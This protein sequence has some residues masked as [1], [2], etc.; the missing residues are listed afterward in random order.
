MRKGDDCCGGVDDQLPRVREMKRRSGDKPN[1]NYKHSTAK[2]PGA[3]KQWMN[4]AQN[5]GT[6]P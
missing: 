1:N 6:R 5:T 3:A 4:A 2:R